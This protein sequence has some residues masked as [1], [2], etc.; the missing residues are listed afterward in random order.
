MTGHDQAA[1]AFG[2]G[3]MT[4]AKI[5]YHVDMAAG[6]RADR[7][8]ASASDVANADPADLGASEA[9]RF[10]ATGL[11]CPP[12]QIRQLQHTSG[13]EATSPHT[14]GLETA[15]MKAPSCEASRVKAS[16]MKATKP[17][18]T[19]KA[20]CGCDADEQEGRGEKGS[21]WLPIHVELPR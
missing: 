20:E 7:A 5:G 18:A 10:E 3:D 8:V 19:A 15:C 13:F 9:S 11:G 4:K 12:L 21:S 14:P 16:R 1:S 6:G 2:A 17:T